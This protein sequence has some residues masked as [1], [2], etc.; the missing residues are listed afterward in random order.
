MGQLSTYVAANTRL[1]FVLGVDRYLPAVFAKLHP[2]WRTPYVSIL[3]Q[4]ALASV[5]LLVAQLGE[6]LRSGYQIL[7]DMMGIATLIPFVYIFASGFKFGHRWAGAAGGL[8]AI[9]GVILAIVPPPEVASV[10]L[11]ELKVAGGTMLIAWIGRAIFQRSKALP[12]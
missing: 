7:V 2:R 10:W 9:A 8:I 12:T 5:L 1:P 11:F 3:A 4:A 6:T